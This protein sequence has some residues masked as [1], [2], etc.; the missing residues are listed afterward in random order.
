MGE[1]ALDEQVLPGV[2]LR[3]VQRLLQV[4]HQAVPALVV[5]VPQPHLAAVELPSAAD[6]IH[7]LAHL[8]RRSQVQR[9]RRKQCARPDLVVLAV[10]MD[11]QVQAFRWDLDH[12]L[13]L[14][15]RASHGGQFGGLGRYNIAGL[16]GLGV[17]EHVVLLGC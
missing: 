15:R 16:G 9:K 3:A 10:D 2:Q 7:G 17:G 6:R 4:G 14:H 11:D 1:L 5:V 8:V 12:R 13:R